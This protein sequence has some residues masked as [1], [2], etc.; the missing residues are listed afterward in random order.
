MCIKDSTYGNIFNPANIFLPDKSNILARE[1]FQKKDEILS[2]G[3]AI[4]SRGDAITS[5]N[6]KISLIKK[7][8]I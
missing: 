4:T 7:I 1:I 5:K 6:R 2:K 3:D 8:T